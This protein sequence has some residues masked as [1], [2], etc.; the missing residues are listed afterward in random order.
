MSLGR[1][2]PFDFWF[3]PFFH[4]NQAEETKSF[5]SVPFPPLSIVLNNI[6]ISPSS[7]GAIN[8]WNSSLELS[9]SSIIVDIHF[10][11]TFRT[12]PIQPSS[13]SLWAQFM[14]YILFYSFKHSPSLC[15]LWGKLRKCGLE[16]M[17]RFLLNL[18]YEL[19]TCL[20]PSGQGTLVA[21]QVYG[22]G[23]VL[24]ISTPKQFLYSGW[25]W[26]KV[27]AWTLFSFKNGWLSL[28]NFSC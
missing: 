2:D 8:L 5:P 4:I 6:N 12:S 24:E 18:L 22:V 11:N 13:T 16:G 15:N 20:L 14:Y 26:P 9:P 7:N 25:L 10:R 19:N 21:H 27:S 3:F 17:G 28:A 23:L 1:N